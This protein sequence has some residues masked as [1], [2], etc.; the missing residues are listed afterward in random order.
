MILINAEGKRGGKN[1]VSSEIPYGSTKRQLEL[2][3]FIKAYIEAN[4]VPPSFDEMKDALGLKSKSGI[5]RLLD[6]LERRRLIKR[7]KN[8]SRSIAVIEPASQAPTSRVLSL[9]KEIKDQA[10]AEL[11]LAVRMNL[12]GHDQN[13]TMSNALAQFDN[14]QEIAWERFINEA[15]TQ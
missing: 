15:E 3:D 10:V 6:S 9:T 8:S 14:A 11:I 1:M 12:R 4:S 2:Y 13:Q 5:Y 7:L